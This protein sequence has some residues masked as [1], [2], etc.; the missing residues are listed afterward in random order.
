MVVG[1]LPYNVHLTAPETEQQDGTD[2]NTPPDLSRMQPERPHHEAP[3][4]AI[5]ERRGFPCHEDCI[6]LRHSENNPP[7]PRPIRP[8][9]VGGMATRVVRAVLALAGKQA[10]LVDHREQPWASVT[11]SGTR[12]TLALRFTGWEACDEGEALIAALPLH[13]FSVTGALVVDVSLKRTDEVL[14]PD[15]ML[16]IELELLL[17][18]QA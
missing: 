5:H 16:E 9:S 18:D 8:G 4:R 13:D 7:S 1:F 10:Q 15:R 14:V 11:F 6:M 2:S 3:L 12:H 17:L